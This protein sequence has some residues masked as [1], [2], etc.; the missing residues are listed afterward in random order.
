MVGEVEEKKLQAFKENIEIIKHESLKSFD[1][2]IFVFSTGFFAL[3]ILLINT[4]SLN[5]SELCF[6]SILYTAWILNSL[7]VF[8][9]TATHLFTYC[10]HSKTLKE[11]GRNKYSRM[12]A[13]KRNIIAVYTNLVLLLMMFVIIILYIIFLSINLSN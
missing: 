6:K 9:N 4:L 8:T 1:Q 12:K 11:I 5:F 10:Q 3:S 13:Q 2:K 7:V